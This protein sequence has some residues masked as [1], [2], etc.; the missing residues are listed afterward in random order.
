MIQFASTTK[1]NI[2]NY[3]IEARRKADNIVFDQTKP[4]HIRHFNAV[5][6]S[7]KHGVN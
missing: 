7:F 4:N 6:P 2:A 3:F 1:K 5:I